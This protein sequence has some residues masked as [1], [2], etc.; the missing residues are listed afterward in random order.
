MFPLPERLWDNIY[1][2]KRNNVT[3]IVEY[4][5]IKTRHQKRIYIE[6]DENG[7]YKTKKETLK[8][9]TSFIKR[10]VCVTAAAVITAALAACG[11][12]DPEQTHRVTSAPL[13]EANIE[14]QAVSD[15]L[16]TD[17]TEV[18]TDSEVTSFVTEKFSDASYVEKIGD[19]RYLLLYRSD[20]VDYVK[21]YDKP[22]DSIINKCQVERGSDSYNMP[23]IY[24]DKG[25]GFIVHHE[26]QQCINGYYYD[27]AGEL[28][29]KFSMDTG[30][31]WSTESTLA[32]DGSAMYVVL[33][34][35]TYSNFIDFTDN[36]GVADIKFKDCM[37]Q[38]YKVSASEE[39]QIAE[40]DAHTDIYSI[41]ATADGE[42]LA[43]NYY[44][45][46][47]F[48]MG[49]DNLEKVQDIEGS[50]V[51]TADEKKDDEFGLA[52]ISTE[53][54]ADN[55]MEKLYIT[56]RYI[57]DLVQTG[58][59]FTV[60][61]KDKVVRID[62]DE[63]GEYHQESYSMDI[64]DGQSVPEV[65]VSASGKYMAYPTYTY[66]TNNSKDTLVNVVRFDDGEAVRIYEKQHD[67]WFVYFR[68]RYNITLIDEDEGTLITRYDDLT[69]SGKCGQT[70]TAD[71]F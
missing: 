54:N 70:Y 44:Y 15:V 62:L 5:A 33:S 56:D 71:I 39:K 20:D 18:T 43:L 65:Y 60:V 21:I 7:L 53:K 24:Q 37:T 26:K 2:I 29:N 4:F 17:D 63:N 10:T 66:D 31:H 8:M 67:G 68:P 16:T 61:G 64:G 42:H 12:T 55:E 11:G 50:S 46:P 1:K 45:H 3:V 51:D 34:D 28:V 59:V 58:N 23:I 6:A 57:E 38:V 14:P 40:F 35:K 69:T 41:Y 49:F 27:T 9:K 36:D 25:F 13:A 19:G 22:S 32:P 47:Q 52:L 48:R 30:S